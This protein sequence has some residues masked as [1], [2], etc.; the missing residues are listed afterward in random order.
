MKSQLMTLEKLQEIVKVDEKQRYELVFRENGGAEG[1]W[2][3]RA[4]QGHSIKVR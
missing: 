4:Q 1:I 2:L 3:I